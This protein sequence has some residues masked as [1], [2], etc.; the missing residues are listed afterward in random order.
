MLG[1]SGGPLKAKNHLSEHLSRE[2]LIHRC[3]F[4]SSNTVLLEEGKASALALPP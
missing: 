2:C 4:C 1:A 3:V